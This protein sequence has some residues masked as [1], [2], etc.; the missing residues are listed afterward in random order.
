MDI[1]NIKKL[2][3]N[4]FNSI[5]MFGNNFGLMKNKTNAKKLLKQFFSMTYDDAVIVA[6][7]RDPYITN[8]QIH[9]AYLDRNRQ[10]GR[11][12]GQIRIRARFMQYTSKW[13]DYLYVSKDEMTN[14]ISGTGW[15]IK[16]F[17]DSKNYKENGQYIAIMVKK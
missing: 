13:F 2:M 8:N 15:E 1:S 7:D 9:F 3:P 16:T 4:K 5:I 14:L 6:E 17:I 11:M 12:P 10:L